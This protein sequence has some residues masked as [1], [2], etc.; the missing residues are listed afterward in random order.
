[1]LLPGDLIP[2]IFQIIL[3]DLVLSGHNA[4]VI[5]LAAH[6]LPLRQ[7]RAAIL[8]GGGAALV[9]RVGLTVFAAFLLGVPAVK[10]I[11][12]L[13]LL[14]IAYRLLDT[15]QPGDSPAREE[16][17]SLRRAIA[18]IL[19]ADVVM[20]LDNVLGVAAAS[21]GDIVLLTFG[22]L[23]SMAI[24]MF[25]G[26]AF[27]EAIDRM[28]W[29]AYLGALVIAWT[30]VDMIQ[31]DGL[32]SQAAELPFFARVTVSA[33]ISVAVVA[34]GHRARQRPSATRQTAQ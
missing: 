10:A 15:E 23:G 33:L 18:T 26:G 34:L 22:L 2:R 27:A 11:G 8:I 4:L 20:S 14:W 7:R 3:I 16:T 5:G 28:R 21:D 6:P 17:T 19:V 29:L 31:D 32:V 12:G 9:L 30:G 1:V 25:G 24:V 13:L